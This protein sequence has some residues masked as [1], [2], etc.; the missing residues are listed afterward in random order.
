MEIFNILAPRIPNWYLLST[1]KPL[2][3]R[4]QRKTTS[5]ADFKSFLFTVFVNRFISVFFFLSPSALTARTAHT[6]HT[7]IGFFDI[8]LKLLVRTCIPYIKRTTMIVPPSTPSTSIEIF[9]SRPRYFPPPASYRHRHPNSSLL[10]LVY[11]RSQLSSPRPLSIEYPYF[12]AALQCAS[13]GVWLALSLPF[14]FAWH[15]HLFVRS[16]EQLLWL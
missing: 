11:V 15:S 4:R 2:K 3:K 9:P 13:T 6:A 14:R 1:I 10:P 12:T 5:N 8:V 16:S 7:I